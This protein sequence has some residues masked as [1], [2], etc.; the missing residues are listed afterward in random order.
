VWL[1]APWLAS[2]WDNATLTPLI[3]ASAIKLLFVGVALVPLSMLNRAMKFE[4]I[5]L[6][7][8][9]ATFGSGLSTVVLAWSGFGAW[10]FV[11]GQLVYGLVIAVAAFALSPFRPF[12]FSSHASSRWRCLALARPAQA[13]S[14]TCTETP[15]TS[16]WGV[17]SACR[18]W[19]CTASASSSR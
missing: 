9:L 11:L 18:Q 7:N 17:S 10:A 8:T 4:R 19:V 6:A 15:T 12:R 1:A 16:S 13:S 3:R 5:A 2:I 14:T